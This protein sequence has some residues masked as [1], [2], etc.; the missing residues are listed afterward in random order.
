MLSMDEIHLGEMVS[1]AFFHGNGAPREGVPYVAGR[2]EGERRF[3]LPGGEPAAIEAWVGGVQHGKTTTFHNGEKFTEVTFVKGQREGIEERFRD[4]G[5]RVAQLVKWKSGKMH[6]PCYSY[7]GD[8]TTVD[9]Y[10]EGQ[11]VTQSTYQWMAK[12][13][14][15]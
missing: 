8:E 11:S 3:F 12:T 4:N 5:S 13:H 14:T 2:I 7:L 9:W 6:G 1:R 15:H 10:F